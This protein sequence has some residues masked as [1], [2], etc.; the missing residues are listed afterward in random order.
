MA[1][2]RALDLYDSAFPDFFPGIFVAFVC[3]LGDLL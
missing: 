1:F 2:G 3:L